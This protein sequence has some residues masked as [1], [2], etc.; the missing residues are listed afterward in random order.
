MVSEGP[1]CSMVKPKGSSEVVAMTWAFCHSVAA[2]PIRWDMCAHIHV[3]MRYE[4]MVV[5][6]MN[7][8]TCICVCSITVGLW[9]Y[10]P[11]L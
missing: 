7:E 10:V 5:H 1:L 2:A 8:C 4:L 6:I 9:S 11:C 3:C